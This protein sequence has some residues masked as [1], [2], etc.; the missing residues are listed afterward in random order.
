MFF[1]ISKTP[2]DSFETNYQLGPF[3]LGTDKGWH[4]FENSSKLVIYKGY[5]DSDPLPALLDTIIQQEEPFITGNFCAIVY[6]TLTET[7]KIK[8]DRYR[9]FP[10]FVKNGQEVSNMPIAK[11]WTAWTDSLV[12]I[13]KNFVVKEDKFD[14]IG[15]IDTTPIDLE[16]ALE[17]VDKI[18]ST[19]TQWF[20]A[21]NTLPIRAH[22]SG[23]VDSL[24]VFSYLQ[25]YTNKYQMVLAQHLDYDW[26]WLSNSGTI[27]KHYWGY[28]QIHHWNEP[29]VLTSGAPGDEFMLRSPGTLDLWLKFH[30][31]E[32]LQLL[33]L[34]EWKSC[35]HYNYFMKPSNYTI[36]EHQILNPDLDREGLFRELCNTVANDWQHWH[37]GNT[38]TW[39]PL[40]DLEIFK[41]MLRL[42]VDDGLG[43]IMNSDFSKALIE[44]NSP[45]LS[46]FISDKKNVGNPMK[47]LRNLFFNNAS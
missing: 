18:L 30:K 39:T 2:N 3:V 17:L 20:L 46:K 8:T 37:L 9:G 38:L 43:Q 33:E 22:L 10:I 28:S 13:D 31:L 21:N 25:K 32:M 24:L 42:S 47:N 16:T 4:F 29:C 6:D 15:V 11:D 7:I 41:I 12:T 26:F 23:G 44:R 19:K 35:L 34:P 5:A 27:K 45:G 14:L 1:S 40:R 36:F